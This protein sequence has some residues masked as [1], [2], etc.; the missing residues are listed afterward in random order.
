MILADKIIKYRKQLGYSQEELA[1]KLGVSRQAVSKWESTLSIPDLDKI[2]KMSQLF[3]VSTD[4]LVLDDVE[5]ATPS[6]EADDLTPTLNLDETN[7]YMDTVARAAIKIAFGTL[8]C[9]ISPI[10]LIVLTSMVENNSTQISES[11]ASGIGLIFLI[12]VVA[13][14]VG[15]FI[16]YGMQLSEFQYLDQEPFNLAYGVEG[17]VRQRKKSFEQKYRITLII[18]IGLCILSVLPI[19]FMMMLNRPEDEYFIAITLLLILVSVGVSFIIKAA[20]VYGS[21]QKLLQE[22][23]YQLTQKTKRKKMDRISGA[24]WCTITAIYL[25]V[26]FLTFA[27]HITWVIWVVAGVLYGAIEALFGED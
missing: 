2:I 9:I 10:P 21:Y 17:I 18:G 25:A 26:S 6:I 1:D 19:F 15:H 14:A 20:M 5:D 4:Y 8:L 13:I 3:G 23:D 22:G 11:V 27:W 12:V 7:H 16:Y 24:Y